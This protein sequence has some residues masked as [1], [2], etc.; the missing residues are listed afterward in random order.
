[1]TPNIFRINDEL[2]D[3]DPR[4]QLCAAADRLRRFANTSV[5]GLDQDGLALLDEVLSAA[6]IAEQSIAMQRARIRYLEGLSIT[7]DLTGLLNRRGFD[8]ELDRA[9][10]RARRQGET[11][12]LLLCDLDHFKSIND[13]F[14]HAAGDA[15]LRRVA[16]LLNRNTRDTDHVGRPGGDEF[17]ILMTL[18]KCEDAERR[19]VDLERQV[20]ALTVPWKDHEIPV[21]ASFGLEFY[22]PESQNDTLMFL[23][24]RQLYKA[25]GPRLVALSS[26]AGVD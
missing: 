1:M 24:D 7:D 2:P 23:A 20:N 22:G 21:S 9:L 17:A 4:P 3:I 19:C 13:T 15:V 18:T 8:F 16:S 11:G 14:G 12:L 26:Q 10:S 25:K 5:E 6:A